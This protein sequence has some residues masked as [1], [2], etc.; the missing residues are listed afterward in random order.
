[1]R[2]FA[3]TPELRTALIVGWALVILRSLTFTLFEHSHFDSDQAVVG[4]MAKHLSEGRAFPLFFYGQSYMLAVEA[5][6]AAPFIWIGGATVAALRASLIATNL[7]VITLLIVGL[8]R[9]GGLRPYLALA[10][11]MFLVFP[12][13]AASAA[14]V[15]AQGGNIEPFL[16]VLVLWFV[17]DRPFWFGALLALGFL[18]REFVLYAVPVLVLGQLWSGALF[19]RTTVRAW[20]VSA[21]AFV[22][23]WQGVH[24][25]VPLSDTMGP[26]TR[27]MPVS[28]TRGSQLENLAQRAHLEVGS[29]P[30]RA[31]T[32]LT[33]GIGGLVG[34]RRRP[35]SGD[36]RNWVG[37]L[38]GVSLFAASLR[39]LALLRKSPG[40]KAT[41][42]PFAWYVLGVGV[43]AALAYAVARPGEEL[44]ERYIL[45][46]L[47]I[48]VGVTAIWLALEPHVRVRGMVV[49][50]TLGC[51]A[52]AGIDHWKR[53]DLYASGQVPNPIRELGAVLESRG[54]SV[55]EA[56]YW[57]AYKLTFVTGERVKVAATDVVRITEYQQLAAAAGAG[58]VR[59]AESPCGGGERVGHFFLCP[60]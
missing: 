54:I 39:V 2:W 52:L 6:W 59:I 19:Q 9:S 46:S 17:R 26:G 51:A 60:R 20:A 12:P 34:G 41:P 7:C 37:I 14:L 38:L 3:R 30:V 27:G 35:D 53:F 42:A 4:L 18:N 15:E 56:P 49:A 33:T 45:L 40:G 8:H 43:V 16:W 5:W 44:R 58:V 31:F 47:F 28:A 36:G 29:L 57:R 25:L 21:V 13:P 23:V 24:A 50:L 32:V 48:P 1:M 55:A 22:A 11:A 10:A